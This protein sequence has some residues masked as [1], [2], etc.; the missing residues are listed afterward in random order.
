L[1]A[2]VRPTL[3]V[4]TSFVHEAARPEPPTSTVLFAKAVLCPVK[5]TT[6]VEVSLATCK[7]LESSVAVI[8]VSDGVGAGATVILI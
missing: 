1:A 7:L 8:Q 3:N 2:V 4:H 6:A 5:V